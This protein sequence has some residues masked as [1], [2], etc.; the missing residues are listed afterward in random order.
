MTAAD[1]PFV[2]IATEIGDIVVEIYENKAPA[3]A[4]HFLRSVD[5]GY[6][7]GST[8][9]RAARSADNQPGDEVK[10]DVVQGGFFDNQDETKCPHPFI[11]LET[12]DQ[13]GIRHLDGVISM[14]R[15]TPDSVNTLF[16]IC[17]GDQPVLDTGGMRHK[18]GLGFA[19]FGRV[20]AGM[21]LVRRMHGMKTEGQY[22]VPQVG[23]LSMTR[24]PAPR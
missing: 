8:F 12:T 15:D 7:D 24:V 13:T 16:F 18:D 11:D 14:G 4:R 6:Y 21:D 19:A 2:R 20:T 9:Y 10:I 17:V 1:N 5:E 23:I 22:I 3:T